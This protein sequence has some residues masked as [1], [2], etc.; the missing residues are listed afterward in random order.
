MQRRTKENEIYLSPVEKNPVINCCEAANSA[1]T[2]VLW[3]RIDQPLRD[4]TDFQK[5][6]IHRK[7]GLK[8]QWKEGKKEII[9][10]SFLLSYINY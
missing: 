4:L 2:K 10:H 5:F 7:F 9:K 1:G 6:L 8:E 3:G